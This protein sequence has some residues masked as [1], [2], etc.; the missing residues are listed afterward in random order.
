MSGASF[1]QRV[2]PLTAAEDVAAAAQLA[3]LLE[4]SAPKPGN[5]HPGRAFADTRYEDFLASAAAI[6]PAMAAAGQRPLGETIRAAVEA[7]RRWTRANTNL[8]IILLL[9]PLARAALANASADSELSLRDRVRWVLGRTTVGDARQVYH[10]IRLASPGGL[11][12]VDSQD[13]SG[14]P[15]VTLAEAMALA[16]D[17]DAIAAEYG[18]GF[19]TTF[20]AGAPALREALASGLAWSDA[21]VETFLVLLASSPDTLIGRKLGRAAAADVSRR[22]RAVLDAGGVRSEAGRRAMATFDGELRAS[23]N[24]SNPGTTADL[25]AAALFVVLLEGH[26][27][28]A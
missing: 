10:A 18:T 23:R 19:A 14:E 20:Q 6:G 9:A 2:S 17:R 8:G 25:T 27:P 22:A 7:T 15:T 26:R 1:T 21:T 3:C 4:A 16:A 13:V 5:V 12:T 28:A 11:G 24:S